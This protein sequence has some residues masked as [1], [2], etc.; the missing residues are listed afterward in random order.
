MLQW[1]EQITRAHALIYPAVVQFSLVFPLFGGEYAADQ[2]ELTNEVQLC[3]WMV[4]WSRTKMRRWLFDFTLIWLLLLL[5]FL[6]FLLF[7]LGWAR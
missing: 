5:R 3:R 2:E 1:V 7:L 4:P 6:L